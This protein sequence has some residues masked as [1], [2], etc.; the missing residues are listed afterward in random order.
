MGDLQNTK[1]DVHIKL[2]RN[3]SNVQHGHY[4][5]SPI[6]FYPWGFHPSVME[7]LRIAEKEKGR[8]VY[9]VEVA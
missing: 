3:R 5:P 9:S 4:L 7:A 6:L 1:V 2:E 8:S